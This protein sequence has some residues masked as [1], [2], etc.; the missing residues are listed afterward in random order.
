[1]RDGCRRR[2]LACARMRGG[3][4]LKQSFPALNTFHI[5]TVYGNKWLRT[6]EAFANPAGPLNNKELMCLPQCSTLDSH[7]YPDSAHAHD[8][9]HRKI[10]LILSCSH[11]LISSC[12]VGMEYA[13][14]E[15]H[16]PLAPKRVCVWI[17]LW[18][19]R[20]CSGRSLLFSLCM[21]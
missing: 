19:M 15:A 4:V 18:A 14:M 3:S 1:M 8:K 16:E 13:T 12:A 11:S 9:K 5:H 17:V 6:G 7:F 10:L 20:R 2:L 21:N